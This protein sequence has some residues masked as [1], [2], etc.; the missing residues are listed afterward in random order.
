MTSINNQV[1]EPVQSLSA[2]VSRVLRTK[3]GRPRRASLARGSKNQVD[4]RPASVPHEAE[5]AV[6]RGDDHREGSAKAQRPR[7]AGQKKRPTRAHANERV[8]KSAESSLSVVED[9]TK[10]IN[11]HHGLDRVRV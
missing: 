10:N 8:V 1:K 6:V 4:A 5:N 11:K 3:G 9:S 2:P 7:R